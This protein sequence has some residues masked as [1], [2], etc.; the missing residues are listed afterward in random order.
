MRFSQNGLRQIK[1]ITYLIMLFIDRFEFTQSLLYVIESSICV[2][3]EIF[4]ITTNP[5]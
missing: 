3:F 4:I 5:W 1:K 2:F